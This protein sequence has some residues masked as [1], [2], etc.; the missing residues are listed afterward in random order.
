[1]DEIVQTNNDNNLELPTTLWVFPTIKL[2]FSLSVNYVNF[3]FV[4]T[5]QWI[6]WGLM[7]TSMFNCSLILTVTLQFASLFITML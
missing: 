6:V 1:L 4:R 7:N 5:R 2:E 3:T